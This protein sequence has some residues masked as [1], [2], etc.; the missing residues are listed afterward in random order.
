[1]LA[2]PSGVG[3]GSVVA[4]ARELLPTL[5][6]SVSWAT[7]APRP[8]EA[9]GQHYHFVDEATFRAEIAAG[10]FLEWAE[11]AGHY[12]GTPRAAV[13]EHLAAGVPSLLEIDLQG[14]RQVRRA[15]P[16]ALLVF[17]APPSL[18]ELVRRLA[19]RGTE[20]AAER[21]ARMRIAEKELAAAAEFDA[22]VV[23]DDV[24]AAAARLVALIR[25]TG[26]LA[27]VSHPQ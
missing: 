1:M 12:K 18:D 15:M 20:D 19:G 2:G 7:R 21:A 22:T 25:S 23:N 5:W 27:P 9:D 13:E 11:Y 14:A 26:S 10:G 3:K 6:V 16:A 24:G 17:L 4:R 8:D